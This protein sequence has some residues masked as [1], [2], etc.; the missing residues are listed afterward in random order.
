MHVPRLS[1]AKQLG[2]NEVMINISLTRMH[3]C[4]I[5][6]VYFHCMHSIYFPL[7]LQE[8]LLTRQPCQGRQTREDST[9]A[10]CLIAAV[11]L[12]QTL[13]DKRYPQ[14]LPASLEGVCVCWGGG[15]GGGGG[16]GLGTCCKQPC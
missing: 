5:V 1:E 8:N 10:K 12:S 14:L 4:K 11:K 16:I 3:L 9:N 7:T 2:P 6:P 15:G 13:L